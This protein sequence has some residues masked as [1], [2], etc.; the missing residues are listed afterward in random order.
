MMTER[1]P[2]IIPRDSCICILKYLNHYV[3]LY[4]RPDERDFFTRTLKTG[5]RFAL[6][7]AKRNEVTS[8]PSFPPPTDPVRI[9]PLTGFFFLGD[10]DR[11]LDA[12]LAVGSV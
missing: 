2:V 11:A 10:D 7:I 9:P 4:T 5:T 3:F 1:Q 6:F 12:R 8:F